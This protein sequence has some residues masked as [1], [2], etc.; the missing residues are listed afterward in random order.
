M[1]KNYP[2]PLIRFILF[3]DNPKS[4]MIYI[5]KTVGFFDNKEKAK[6]CLDSFRCEDPNSIYTLSE[7]E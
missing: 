4:T 2:K 1:V 5:K 7:E 3:V 6:E